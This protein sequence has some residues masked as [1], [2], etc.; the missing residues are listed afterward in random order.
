M[1]VV[2]T[3]VLLVHSFMRLRRLHNKVGRLQE[4]YSARQHDCHL[5]FLV[6]V[7]I[8]F[9]QETGTH[10][11]LADFSLHEIPIIIKSETLIAFLLVLASIFKRLIRS[12][13]SKF[14]VRSAFPSF[15]P[16]S[17][18]D[19]NRNVSLPPSPIKKSPSGSSMCPTTSTLKARKLRR[20][21]PG[22]PSASSAR[23]TGSQNGAAAHG[24][25]GW[26]MLLNWS[27]ERCCHWRTS[28]A[29]RSATFT[30][31]SRSRTPTSNATTNCAARVA[32][33][34]SV[35]H[36]ST[37]C[38]TRLR[39]GSRRV[40]HRIGL[41]HIYSEIRTRT[42]DHSCGASSTPDPLQERELPTPLGQLQIRAVTRKQ[43]L[44][45][46]TALNIQFSEE[47]LRYGFE[48]CS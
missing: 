25:F 44:Q 8:E 6:S 24:L 15:T 9:K 32:R 14:S 45:Y 34:I 46:L 11:G 18:N 40:E 47:L 43:A 42:D 48:Q 23:S 5:R 33:A 29:S 7:G 41:H 3:V 37:R 39:N 38:R 36:T 20:T 21:F 12:P 2:S 19:T 22:R 30:P 1:P 28:E 16:E 31:E 13:V 4:D 10:N 35:L 27:A 17:S 26:T